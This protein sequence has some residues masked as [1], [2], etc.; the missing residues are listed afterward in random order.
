MA[1][2]C[3]PC[4]C[5]NVLPL[6]L[7]TYGDMVTLILTFFILLLSMVT[8]DAKKLTEAEGS[9]KGSLSLLTGG[10]KIEP[11][12]TRIQQQADITNEPES[13]EVVKKIESE[14]LD[15]KENVK[16]SL[17]PSDIVDDGSNGFILRFNGKLLF[18][19]GETELTNADD[20]LFL[21]RVA[22]ILQKMPPNLH[23]D[24]IGYTDNRNIAPT[25]KYSDSL[26]L[27]ALRALGVT[28]IL[29]SNGVS[30]KKV[31]SFGAGATN[32][33]LPNT[34]SENKAQNRRVE[35]RFYPVD[36]H[37]HKTM[38]VLQKAIETKGLQNNTIPSG[39]L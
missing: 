9:L 19:E 1:K 6:W 33:V 29:L 20:V 28:R 18:D 12:N 38:N 34:S 39:N 4:D 22:L 10:I 32:F 36:R 7:G 24:I 31:T 16:V 23:T 35:F 13:A 2:R 21:K 3:P 14:I 25:A 15:F 26:G 8:F 27:S 30:P 11:D 5:P 37:L 17:G